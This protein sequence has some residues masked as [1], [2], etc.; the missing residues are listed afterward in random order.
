MCNLVTELEGL[1]KRIPA[2]VEIAIFRTEFLAAV[3]FILDGERRGVGLIEHLDSAKAD[4]N[5]SGRH[6]RVFALALYNSSGHLK[7]PLTAY[8]RGCL[9]KL[10]GSR[11]VNHELGDAITV[12]QVDEGHSAKFPGFLNPS[13]KSNDLAGIFYAEL[14]A[15]M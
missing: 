8:G 4:F 6:L 7:H 1:L 11:S 12:T 13:G 2:K 3:A 10:C 5:V 9:D 14:S 15:S